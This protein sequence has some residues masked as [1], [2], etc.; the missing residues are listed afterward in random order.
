ML[1]AI[2][3]FLT[4]G[5]SVFVAVSFLP[6]IQPQNAALLRWVRCSNVT[7]TADE[8]RPGDLFDRAACETIHRFASHHRATDQEEQAL[9]C[10]VKRPGLLPVTALLHPTLVRL[11]TQMTF[12]ATGRRRTQRVFEHSCHLNALLACITVIAVTFPPSVGIA[13]G[14]SSYWLFPLLNVLAF[15]KGWALVRATLADIGVL[16]Q[17]MPQHD[18]PGPCTDAC[19]LSDD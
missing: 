4:V 10:L 12:T 13:L 11:T 19:R 9:L 17:V 1:E 18:E 3:G 7:V 5:V 14:H 16:N 2:I 15:I 6:A 8:L